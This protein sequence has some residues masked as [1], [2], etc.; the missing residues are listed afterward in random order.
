MTLC[1]SRSWECVSMFW[2]RTDR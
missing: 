2:Q 1:C